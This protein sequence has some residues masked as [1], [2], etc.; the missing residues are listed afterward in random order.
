MPPQS[1]D[2]RGPLSHP[3][4]ALYWYARLAATLAT[5]IHVVG[6]GWQVYDLTGNPL[7]L[8]LVGLAQFLPA[9]LLLFVS[10]PVADRY[11]RRTILVLFRTIEALAAG[12]LA[13]ASWHGWV[14][15][16]LVFGFVFIIGTARAFEMP[17]AQSLLPTLLP[18]AILSRGIALSS[19][20]NQAATIVGPAIGGFLYVAGPQAVYLTSTTLFLVAAALMAGV[21]DR[22]E[23]GE[24]P[25]ITMEYMFAGIGFIRRR[26]ILL[27]AI[28]L[29]MFA[30]LLGG[31]TALLPVYARD[32][33]GTGPWG[34]GLL[35]SAPAVGAL[36]VALWLARRSMDHRVGTKLFVA[37]AVFGVATL[38][39][40]TSSWLPLSLI[41]LAL[42]GGADMIS[43]VIRMSLVQLETPDRMRGRV[44]AV[45]SLFI[46]ASNQI[47]EFRAGVTAAFIG[48]VPAV[49]LGGLGTLVIV[50]LWIR[51][52]P[53]LA[54]RDRMIEA[55]ASPVPPVAVTTPR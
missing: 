18:P 5:Q 37:V 47:G 17:A 32:I 52:F 19:S 23:G 7:D 38:V 12:M 48:A 27:G 35:R 11:N 43:V 9:M 26:P 2:M 34:L 55:A 54:R 1:P 40:A 13:Y 42:L 22:R 44:G 28:S 46:G 4:Y 8:G 6:V 10:G 21:R 51:L 45:N 31:A 15:R 16:E 14:T 20:A 39:F 29:D 50:G 36:L 33:L 25:K 41:A 49:V 53:E 3:Q 30:V 24:L